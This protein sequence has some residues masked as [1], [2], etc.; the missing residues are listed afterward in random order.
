MRVREWR[1]Q[2]SHQSKGSIKCLM[3]KAEGLYLSSDWT[4][5]HMKHEIHVISMQSQRVA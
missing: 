3:K 1:E 5:R 2:H 4:Y